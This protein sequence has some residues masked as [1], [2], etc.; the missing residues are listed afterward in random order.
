MFV[1]PVW[2]LPHGLFSQCWARHPRLANNMS[3]SRSPLGHRAL[4]SRK[5]CQEV[6]LRW[7]AL[8]GFLSRCQV[9]ACHRGSAYSVTDVFPCV[10]RI[11]AGPD[12]ALCSGDWQMPWCQE[13]SWTGKPHWP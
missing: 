3:L 11:L 13:S 6:R 1:E 10:K 2:F 4:R 7:S 12:G 9:S 8:L 5:S